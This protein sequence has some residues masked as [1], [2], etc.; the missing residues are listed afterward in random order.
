MVGAVVNDRERVRDEL[1]HFVHAHPLASF[2]L[3]LK[4]KL[5][6]ETGVSI[7]RK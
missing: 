7:N 1:R 3:Y 4:S 6:A 5:M 2:L